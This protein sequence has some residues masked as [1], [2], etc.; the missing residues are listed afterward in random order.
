[1]LWCFS[2]FSVLV[3]LLLFLFPRLPG[4]TFE[5]VTFVNDDIK[6]LKIYSFLIINFF[7]KYS[8]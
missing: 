7:P 6:N 2:V 3:A 8:D 4:N 5:S 1:M